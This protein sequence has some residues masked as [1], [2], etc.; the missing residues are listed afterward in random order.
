MSH[1]HGSQHFLE[2]VLFLCSGIPFHVTNQLSNILHR[3]I[4]FPREQINTNDY[5]IALD[6]ET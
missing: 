6:P 3:C 5:F 1:N 2:E 4:T